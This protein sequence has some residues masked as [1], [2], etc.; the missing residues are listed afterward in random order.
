[1]FLL[2]FITSIL[3]IMILLKI[4]GKKILIKL[5]MDS[6]IKNIKI[7]YNSVGRTLTEKQLNELKNKMKY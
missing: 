2:G 7:I 5:L 6:M 1:M 4:Y 3:L